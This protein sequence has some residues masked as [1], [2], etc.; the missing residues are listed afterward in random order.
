MQ[1]IYIISGPIGVGKTTISNS[2]QQRLAN[3]YMNEGDIFLHTLDDR[4]D[5]EWLR[6]LE[7]T[8]EDIVLNTRKYLQDARNVIIDFIVE[9]E[10]D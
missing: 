2:L 9:E 10:L 8:W 3:S 7:L 6:K 5:I 4:D 1:S